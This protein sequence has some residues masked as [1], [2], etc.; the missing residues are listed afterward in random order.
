MYTVLLTKIILTQPS[1][2]HNWNVGSD[3]ANQL[4]PE[5]NFID[6]NPTLKI[7]FFRT[8]VNKV[9][10]W[11][12]GETSTTVSAASVIKQKMSYHIPCYMVR[13]QWSMQH[14]TQRRLLFHGQYQ[15]CYKPK[16]IVWSLN[17]FVCWNGQLILFMVHYTFPIVYE[18]CF[19]VHRTHLQKPKQ[20]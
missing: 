12:D 11:S 8:Y 7:G 9:I 16:I 3:V 18:T 4:R 19:V 17:Y 10:I 14:G 20:Y 15:M 1:F 6:V 5:P 13:I 2:L